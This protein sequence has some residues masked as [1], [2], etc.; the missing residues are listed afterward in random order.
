MT[1]DFTKR[2]K[3]WRA[4]RPVAPPPDHMEDPYDIGPVHMQEYLNET[5]ETPYATVLVAWGVGFITGVIGTVLIY[6]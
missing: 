6:L 5:D 1:D 4:K 2:E 3:A